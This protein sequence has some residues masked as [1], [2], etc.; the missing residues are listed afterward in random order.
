MDKEYAMMGLANTIRKDS[1]MSM[2]SMLTKQ[3]KE[4]LIKLHYS[5]SEA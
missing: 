1:G 3:E 2:I 4:N 5:A